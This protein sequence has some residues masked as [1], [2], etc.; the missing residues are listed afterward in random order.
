[1][2]TRR[3]SGGGEGGGVG[4]GE[5]EGGGEGEAEGGGGD[6]GGGDGG[7]LG[8]GAGGGEH[9]EPSLWHWNVR[10]VSSQ[11]FAVFTAYHF[12]SSASRARH[13]LF[14][15]QVI[16]SKLPFECDAPSPVKYALSMPSSS[17]SASTAFVPSV[18]PHGSAAL[19]LTALLIVDVDHASC[20][21]AAKM[22]VF[23]LDPVAS[24][25][26]AVYTMIWSPPEAPRS[27]FGASGCPLSV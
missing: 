1:M 27:R 5:V 24:Y 7:G 10:S 6:G 12:D 15:A 25:D 9:A 26:A 8:G 19:L 22:K 4:E 2:A 11:C 17:S 20:T 14:D 23:E 3:R 16:A 21:L 18:S 13:A